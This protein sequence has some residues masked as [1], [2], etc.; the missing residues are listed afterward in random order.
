MA[1]GRMIFISGGVR[2]GKSAF[3]EQLVISKR[4]ERAVY[5]ASGQ[6][7]DEEMAARIK[8]HQQDRSGFGW[9]TIEQPLHMEKALPKI[10]RGDVVLWDCVT[11]WLANELYEGW[12]QATP[13][14]EQAGCME[15]KWS[16]MQDTLCKL[17]SQAELLV[18]VSNELMDDVVRD[19]M[20]QKWLGTI[21]RWL[22]AEADEAFEME[23]GIAF[24]KK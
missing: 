15:Q 23:N 24:R 20:Y 6:V 13:C 21:Q 10:Q 2:S 1:K 12:E 22:V 18:V 5:L 9:T 7:Y 11:T 4:K 3:A 16:R 19:E 8:R 14:A 17:R